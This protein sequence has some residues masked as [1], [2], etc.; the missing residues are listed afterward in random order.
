MSSTAAAIERVLP[1]VS[2][3]LPLL[4][5]PASVA[6][7]VQLERRRQQLS[8]DTLAPQRGGPLRQAPAPSDGL[9]LDEQALLSAL[10]D[11][12]GGS[13]DPSRPPGQPLG[14]QLRRLG[15]FF[16][17]ESDAD[18]VTPILRLPALAWPALLSRIGAIAF[19]AVSPLVS[20]RERDALL[21]LLELWACL[22]FA[23]DPESFHVGEAVGGAGTA[24]RS[25]RGAWVV[26]A[27]GVSR[28][29][30][31]GQ[32]RSGGILIERRDGDGEATALPARVEVAE[33][34]RVEA[35]R[36]TPAQ[37]AAFV[38]LARERQAPTP[39]PAVPEALASRTGLTRAEATLLWA[40]LPNLDTWYDDFLGPKLRRVLGL[41]A[42]EATAA[43]ATLRR[44]SPTQRLQL[45]D[46]AM[47]D[48]PAA[49][50]RDWPRP[51]PA[52]SAGAP[53]RPKTPWSKPPHSACRPRPASCSHYCLIPRPTRRSP[54]TGTGRWPSRTGAMCC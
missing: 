36:G 17:G 45:L 19:R 27:D 5:L 9:P 20:Q 33:T 24:G 6:T 21:D 41:K 40:G 11:L 54:S 50:W 43:R 38:K 47:P 53:G 2:H 1:A 14:D 37:L 49:R 32:W 12:G 8:G 31:G 44:A 35:G 3:T 16:A 28:L 34:R 30:A 13:S 39:D 48:D 15:R 25:E 26:L 22:P 4:G 42:G 23:A 51:G 29:S 18:A 10:A 46:A 7:A 52:C